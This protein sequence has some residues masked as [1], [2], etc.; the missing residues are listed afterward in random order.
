MKRG[1]QDRMLIGSKTTFG[2]SAILVSLLSKAEAQTFYV[3]SEFQD[4][5]PHCA[6]SRAYAERFAMRTSPRVDNARCH[7]HLASCLHCHT[8][9]FLSACGRIGRNAKS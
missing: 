4:E 9:S 7:S 5:I 6:Y 2:S 8:A 1:N 3:L